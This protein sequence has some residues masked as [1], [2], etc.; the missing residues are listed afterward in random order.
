MK[1][2][3]FANIRL[4]TERAHGI[5]IMSMAEAFAQAGVAVTLVVSKRQ[6]PITEDPFSF[7][8]VSR[9]F[10]LER[11]PAIDFTHYGRILGALAYHIERIS[12]AKNALRYAKDHPSDYFY[13]RDELTFVRLAKNN[14]PVVFEMH[15]MPKKL[16][17]YRQAFRNCKK[18]IS[19]SHGLKKAL[20][21]AGVPEDKIIVAPDGVKI[22]KFAINIPQEKA[23]LSFGIPKDYYVALYAGLL[24]EWKGYKTLLKIAGILSQNGIKVY[25]AGGTEI[26]VKNLS[27]Q[28][29]NVNFLGFKSHNDM[30]I[31]RKAADL[32][33]VPNS[34]RF[35]ISS[36]Y[37]SPLKLFE[38]MASGVPIVASDVPAL[39]EVVDESTAVFFNPD[40]EESLIKAILS[41][42]NNPEK[43]HSIA[44]NARKEVEQYSWVIRAKLILNSL[45]A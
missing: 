10:K 11:L 30:P 35:P 2:T 32:L 4:P 8:G 26:Q 27:K 29:N 15:T 17:L 1:L 25:V 9:A 12:F 3:Y 18:I 5:Q 45:N 7:Y 33:V 34:A 22:E 43:S 42:K 31:L 24:D 36:Q 38:S 6:T 19:I 16:S 14:H 28:Y 23:R 20:V 44:Q 21:E 37:T 40:N 13:T 41:V 39:R